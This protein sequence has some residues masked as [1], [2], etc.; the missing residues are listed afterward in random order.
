MLGPHLPGVEGLALGPLGGNHLLARVAAH[1]QQRLLHLLVLQRQ[2]LLL[3]RDL[4]LRREASVA[5]PKQRILRGF[6]NNIKRILLL[7]LHFSY[8]ISH[9]SYFVFR[10]PCANNGKGACT[11]HPRYEEDSTFNRVT[12]F[13]W[14]RLRQSRQGCAQGAPRDPF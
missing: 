8:F 10:S 6:Y 4:C 7:L 12:S 1:V 5:E 2:P 3:R 13:S 9:F 11:Q 14:V